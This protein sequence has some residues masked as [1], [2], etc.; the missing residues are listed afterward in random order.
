MVCTKRT[1]NGS[2]I[3]CI[4]PVKSNIVP[5]TSL[6]H[7]T[8]QCTINALINRFSRPA[9]CF[10]YIHC[11]TRWSPN[12]LTPTHHQSGGISGTGGEHTKVVSAHVVLGRREEGGV[13]VG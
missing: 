1:N 10:T 6:C 3:P 13:D 2:E 5:P 4:L 8:Y 9:L 11:P 7:I 12:G